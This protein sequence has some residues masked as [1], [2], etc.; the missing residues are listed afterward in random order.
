MSDKAFAGQV[1]IITGGSSGLG[2][3]IVE[4]LAS[5]G[6]TAV[7]FDTN[8]DLTTRVEAEMKE[9]GYAVDSAV[10]DISDEESVSRGFE[11]VRTKYARLDVLVNSAGITG[12]T[13]DVITNVTRPDFDRVF[14]I[15]VRGSF[16]VTKYAVNEMKKRNYGRVMLI[17]SVSGKEGNATAAAYSASKA[18]VIGLAKAVGKEYAD[19][20]ITINSIAPATVETPLVLNSSPDYVQRQVNRIPMLRMGKI[21]EVAAAIRYA[22]SPEASFHTGFC[23]DVSGGRSTY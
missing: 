12:P 17:A 23:F 1:G 5:E 9:K 6:L 21:E 8:R 10:V 3:G 20:G 11:Y 4:R 2:K 19:T 13:A 14:A 7:I 15:N 16:L 18:A 22:V